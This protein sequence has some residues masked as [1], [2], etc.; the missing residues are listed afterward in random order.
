VRDS[1]DAGIVEACCPASQY[2]AT[3]LT[4]CER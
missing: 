3:A 1:I 2:A 4:F